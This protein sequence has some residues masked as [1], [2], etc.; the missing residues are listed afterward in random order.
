M[1]ERKAVNQ[2]NEYILHVMNPDRIGLFID[3]Y[4]KIKELSKGDPNSELNG[5]IISLE[6]EFDDN[7]KILRKTYDIA[8]LSKKKE[9]EIVQKSTDDESSPRRKVRTPNLRSLNSNIIKKL[10]AAMEEEPRH[11]DVK[12]KEYLQKSGSKPNNKALDELAKLIIR[13]S[14]LE[15]S[16]L[17]RMVSDVKPLRDLGFPNNL[18]KELNKRAIVEGDGYSE[19]YKWDLVVARELVRSYLLGDN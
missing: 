11:E 13:R 17:S 19:R 14:G 4:E 6:H 15:N 10:E 9:Y 3:V 18:E 1:S 5:I 16:A 2:C 12:I 7:I 8:N